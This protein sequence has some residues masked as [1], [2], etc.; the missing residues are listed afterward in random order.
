[1]SHVCVLTPIVVGSWPAI[2]AAV[3]GA[4]SA[5]GYAATVEGE[6]T[7]ARARSKE[8]VETEVPNSEVMAE[9][10]ARGEKLQFERDGVAIEIGVDDRGRCTVCASGAHL[11]KGALKRI[12]EEV[13][14]RVVQQFTYHKLVNELKQR[15]Y[16][17]AEEKLAQDHSIQMRVRQGRT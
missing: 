9:T 8:R 12:G 11:T 3:T 1:M 2:A 6:E 7:K 17:I 14:G 4:L 15:G 5:M 10:L 13:A 16:V